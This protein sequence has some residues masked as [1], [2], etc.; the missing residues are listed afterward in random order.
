MAAPG[1]KA[2]DWI[3]GLLISSGW[4]KRFSPPVLPG[5]PPKR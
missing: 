4:R 3:A 1:L 2:A 5:T